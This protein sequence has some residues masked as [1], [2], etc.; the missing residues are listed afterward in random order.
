MTPQTKY[1]EAFVVFS[2]AALIVAANKEMFFEKKHI[3]N[4]LKDN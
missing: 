1:V 2:A 3:G 4:L